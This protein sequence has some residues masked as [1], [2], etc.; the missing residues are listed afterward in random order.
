[1]KG[2]MR[3]P[4]FSQT[5]AA[6]FSWSSVAT[7]WSGGIMS[8]KQP[9]A[10]RSGCH[11]SRSSRMRFV[12]LL[13]ERIFLCICQR[14]AQLKAF[15]IV[16]INVGKAPQ[17][18]YGGGGVIGRGVALC[19]EHATNQTKKCVDCVSV[20]SFHFISYMQSHSAF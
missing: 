17:T 2:D 6:S 10:I 14:V 19:E 3:A 1:M 18:L 13:E 12:V 9:N 8:R 11:Q 15:T 7:R 20:K 4:L 5:S 16:E